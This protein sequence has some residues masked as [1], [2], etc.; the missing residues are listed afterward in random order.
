MKRTLLLASCLTLSVVACKK[1]E[2]TKDQPAVA[3]PV[4]KPTADK[5]VAPTADKP[6]APT[7]DKPAMT[8]PPIT[9]AVLAPGEVLTLPTPTVHKGDKVTEL[10]DMDMDMHVEAT[11]GKAVDIVNHKHHEQ[12]K[13]ILDGDGDTIRELKITYQADLENQR[14]EGKVKDKP[15]PLLGK[16]FIVTR[17]ADGLTAKHGDGSAASAEEIAAVIKGNRSVG[18]PD[19]MPKLIAGHTWKLGEKIVFS[20]DELAQLNASMA[21]ESIDPHLSGFALTLTSADA[22]VAT[23]DM[24]MMLALEKSP[25]AT[26]TVTLNGTAKV[27]RTTGFPIA[28]GG[29]GPMTGTMGAPFSGTMSV[30]TTFAYSH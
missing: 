11:P 5:P 27:D 20:T 28:I 19:M 13:E 21:S 18:K 10:E 12:L 24:V 15:S 3:T 22:S 4:A 7:A 16:T 2:T 23:F 17:G 29:T 26:M 1:S 14:M 25:T 30:A 9:A 6:V 8:T